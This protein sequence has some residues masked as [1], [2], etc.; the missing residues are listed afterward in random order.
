MVTAGVPG[1]TVLGSMRE[2]LRQQLLKASDSRAPFDW[3]LVLAGIN[4]LYL[5]DL[6]QE[7]FPEL[8]VGG[9][10]GGRAGERAVSG[11]AG[12]GSDRN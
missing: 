8:Q 10:A 12:R 2:S 6:P 4:D 1:A 9:K 11:R 3:V 7:I 5:R